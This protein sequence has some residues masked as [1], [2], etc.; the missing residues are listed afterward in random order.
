MPPF[1]QYD[2][3]NIKRKRDETALLYLGTRRHKLGHFTI[4][5]RDIKGKPKPV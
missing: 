2:Y 5:R 4:S 1:Q 3:G